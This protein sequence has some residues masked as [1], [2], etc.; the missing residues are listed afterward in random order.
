[1]EFRTTDKTNA[2]CRVCYKV[3]E[4]NTEVMFHHYSRSNKGMVIIFCLDCV[5]KIGEMRAE[6]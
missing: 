1:M 6:I 3:I 4:R 5:D 2:R